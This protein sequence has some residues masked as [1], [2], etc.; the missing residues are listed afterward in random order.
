MDTTVNWLKQHI[1]H[2]RGLIS[3]K[4][5]KEWFDKYNFSNQY[6]EILNFTNF[7]DEI[8]P[9][10]PQRIWHLLNNKLEKNKC[11]NQSFKI[12]CY[13]YIHTWG[14]TKFNFRW[15]VNSIF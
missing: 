15:F 7:L 10:L 9:S 14:N 6:Q 3:K 4:C 12:T 13:L 11:K 5:K 8:N 1:L 2:D